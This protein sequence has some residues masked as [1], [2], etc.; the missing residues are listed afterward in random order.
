MF[1]NV[2]LYVRCPRPAFQ[3]RGWAVVPDAVSGENQA[4]DETS[5]WE[6][7]EPQDWL[8][9]QLHCQGC[10]HEALHRDGRCRRGRVCVRDARARRIERFFME[11]PGSADG[12]LDHPYFEVRALAVRFASIF[13]LSPLITDSDAEVRAG[14]A[15]RLPVA[16]I[17][18]MAADPDRRVRLAVASRLGGKALM[19]MLSDE[20]WFVRLIVVRRLAAEC[21]VRAVH[22]PEPDVRRWVARRID[23]KYLGLM[24]CDAEPTVRQIVATRAQEGLLLKLAR[25][26]DIRVRFTSM[27][28]LPLSI[29]ATLPEDSEK[30][31]RDLVARRLGRDTHEANK[32]EKDHGTGP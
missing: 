19:A 25:D 10:R 18:S 27:E 29:V 4:G 17:E 5:A 30:I 9:H 22:D 11:N 3:P 8:G 7:A 15:L 26:D 1:R 14:V 28:R 21:L 13:R 24:V 2:R 16:R 23:R 6:T 32:R 20:D 12:Y 31:I